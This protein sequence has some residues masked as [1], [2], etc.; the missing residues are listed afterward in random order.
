MQRQ[1]DVTDSRGKRRRPRRR[2]SSDSWDSDEED[3]DSNYEEPQA[4]RTRTGRSSGRGGRGGSVHRLGRSLAADSAHSGPSPSL[5]NEEKTRRRRAVLD[6]PLLRLQLAC[7]DTRLEE[8]DHQVSRAEAAVAASLSPADHGSEKPFRLVNPL[9]K[10]VRSRALRN[11]PIP[12]R[13]GSISLFRLPHAEV[14]RLARRGGFSEITGFHYD[15]KALA[16][17]RWPY[18][19]PRPAFSSAWR[20]RAQGANSLFS[21]ALQLRILWHSLRWEEIN[22]PAPSN[23]VWQHR[24]ADRVV[25]RRLLRSRP[26]D[27]CGLALD[28]WLDKSTQLLRGSGGAGGKG[29]QEESSSDPDFES[30]SGR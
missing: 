27:V 24:T 10:P 19:A 11:L 18:P 20:Y 21:V 25:R 13:N 5:T 22:T 28:Y 17:T 16:M 26:R 30:D 15:R 6:L 2:R 3:T 29:G 9:N 7:I 1:Y 12:P 4:P 8:L 23:G 14:A